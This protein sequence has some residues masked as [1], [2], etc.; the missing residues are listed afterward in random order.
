MVRAPTGERRYRRTTGK[1]RRPGS[2]W[3]TAPWPR[4]RSMA[5]CESSQ[6]QRARSATVRPGR[7]RQAFIEQHLE[8]VLVQL[9]GGSDQRGGRLD[10]GGPQSGTT[11]SGLPFG[12]P[13][14]GDEH[15]CR[16]RQVNGVQAPQRSEERVDCP[17]RPA[18]APRTAGRCRP[19]AGWSCGGTTGRRHPGRRRRTAAARAPRPARSTRTGSRRSRARRA[20]CRLDPATPGAAGDGRSGRA[21]AA[22]GAGTGPPFPRGPYRRRA[23]G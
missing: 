16:R 6:G 7:A 18:G 22:W 13:V 12:T 3:G 8:G 10:R 17:E 19:R 11:V 23:A 9:G 4:C 2:R 5:S 14:A 1:D 20:R 21:G 15:P